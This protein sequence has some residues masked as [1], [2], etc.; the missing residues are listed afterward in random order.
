MLLIKQN[1]IQH[2]ETECTINFCT[3]EQIPTK[4]IKAPL[5]HLDN[6]FKNNQ[7]NYMCAL[8]LLEVQK[9]NIIFTSMWW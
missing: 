5:I 1:I 3:Y 7:L 9:L 6:I 8:S 2:Y 4:K